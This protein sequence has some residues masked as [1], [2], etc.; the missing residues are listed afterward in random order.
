MWSADD[1]QRVRKLVD[2][3]KVYAGRIGG[4]SVVPISLDP[5]FE[6]AL[7]INVLLDNPVLDPGVRKEISLNEE[8]I[9][10]GIAR[11]AMT[12]QIKSTPPSSVRDSIEELR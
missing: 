8:M 12:R 6:D 2:L 9:R 10:L 4:D 5:K 7:N 3:E 11:E 1:T